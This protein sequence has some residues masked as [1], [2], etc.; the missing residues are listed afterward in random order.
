MSI[1]D[2]LNVSLFLSSLITGETN[3]LFK[4][5][6][7]IQVY[8]S[9][10]CLFTFFAQFFYYHFFVLISWNSLHNSKMCAMQISYHA[11]CFSTLYKVLCEDFFFKYKIFK[12][13]IFL[14]FM[15]LNLV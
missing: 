11:C 3:Y 4:C 12:F 6:L 10:N 2:R 15:F 13:I 9:V 5:L 1:R 14:S 7:V 8:S